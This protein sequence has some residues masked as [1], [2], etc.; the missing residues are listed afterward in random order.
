MHLTIISFN[1]S[2][3]KSEIHECSQTPNSEI[4]YE[5]GL[6]FIND[7]LVYCND[8]QSKIGLYEWIKNRDD[9]T[10]R[11]KND[12]KIILDESM[13][14]DSELGLGF[15]PIL[16]AQDNPD[17]FEIDYTD[18]VYLIVKGVKW[19]E[20]RLTIKLKF[21]TNKWLVDGSGIVNIAENRR[22][23]R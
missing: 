4:N 7:Y 6:R 23:K 22:I 10:I 21:E 3:S 18:S 17:E 8:L 13:K 9:L 12:L 5:V 20:F 11:F 1:N 2:S 15:D 16:D 14:E 19:P